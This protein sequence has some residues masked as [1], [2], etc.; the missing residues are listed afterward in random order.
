MKTVRTIASLRENLQGWR[1]FDET[2]ALVPTM[3]NL[4]A[5]HLS[6]VGVAGKIADRVV[7]SIFVNPTQFGPTEDFASYPRTLDS[8]RRQLTRAKVDILFLPSVAEMYPYGERGGTVVSVPDLS[9]ILCGA[10][11]PGHFD[12]VASVVA[13]LF[14]IV[15]PDTA[16][17]GQKDYQQ[18]AIVQR[19]QADLCLPIRIVV[20]P[21][22]RD[23]DGLALSS[24]N[25]YLDA[26]GRA[27]APGMHQALRA[28]AARL[29]DGEREFTALET[30]GM[31]D[32]ASAG[33]RPDYFAIRNAVDLSSPTAT[34][35][36]LV[37]LAAGHLG[38]ARLID[39][40]LVDL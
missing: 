40:V 39:N 5:G 1:K 23:P 9:D 15:Q 24:R 17:F 7:V 18:V 22:A 27:R 3:G 38:R 37:V 35:R 28:C 20:A 13:R 12:G 36:K 31:A 34:S 19:L 33:F 21:T 14:N 8:D 11:R 2:I 16:V 6:L 32:L 4:H 10:F 25:Q 29:R 26:D 30:Y